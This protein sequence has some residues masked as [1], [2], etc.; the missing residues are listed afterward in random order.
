M[1]VQNVNLRKQAKEDKHILLVFS[2]A[3]LILQLY[4][5][6]ELN[7]CFFFVDWLLKFVH[8][9][10]Y[11]SELSLVDT[12]LSKTIRNIFITKTLVQFVGYILFIIYFV[13]KIF[14][15][16]QQ[17]DKTL[18]IL[19]IISSIVWMFISIVN[20]LIIDIFISKYNRGYHFEINGTDIK[21]SINEWNTFFTWF[22]I[23]E[24]IMTCIVTMIMFY[25][26][27]NY[28]LDIILANVLLL[29]TITNNWLIIKRY[30]QYRIIYK[31]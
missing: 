24:M 4:C 6:I 2:Y 9:T 16:T 15:Q 1:Q 26:K 23:I 29:I 21:N 20:Y 3:L 27:N 31:N 18:M 12:N 17:F 14:R 8:V 10:R 19:P 13:E 7:N 22:E 5:C 25:I 11:F 30:Y 28:I